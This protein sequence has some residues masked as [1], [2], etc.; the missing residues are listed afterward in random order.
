[1]QSDTSVGEM[2]DVP[3]TNKSAGGYGMLW[4][5]GTCGFESFQA[6]KGL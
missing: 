2:E 3:H 5:R 1:M 4:G 6:G